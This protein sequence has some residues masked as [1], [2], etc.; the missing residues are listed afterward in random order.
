MNEPSHSAPHSSPTRNRRCGKVASHHET[1]GPREHL[2]QRGPKAVY[3]TVHLRT[4]ALAAQCQRRTPPVRSAEWISVMV[5]SR[6][7]STLWAI[8]YSV[9]R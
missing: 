7:Y 5:H 3:D 6:S 4:G 1:G 2:H 8:L 9:P